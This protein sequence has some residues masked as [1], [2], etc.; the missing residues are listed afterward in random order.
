MI[1][2]R[3]NRRDFDKWSEMGNIG[4]SYSDVLPY[5]QKTEN[6]Q[7]G[8]NLNGKIDKDYHGTMGPVN[9]EW[10]PFKYHFDKFFFSD[11]IV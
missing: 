10:I 8:E 6:A 3:G 9:V 5:F 1:Y 11:K 7:F 4:W 2:T